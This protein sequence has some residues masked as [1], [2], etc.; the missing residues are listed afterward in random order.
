VPGKLTD[1]QIAAPLVLLA[2]DFLSRREESALRFSFV[3]IRA[4]RGCVV[5]FFQRGRKANCKLRKEHES[6]QIRIRRTTL[7]LA[8]IS[9]PS[10]FWNSVPCRLVVAA[11][12]Q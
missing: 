5:F 2:T 11:V 8:S 7:L 4:I 6:P 12:D 1:R 10:F 3:R 9:V